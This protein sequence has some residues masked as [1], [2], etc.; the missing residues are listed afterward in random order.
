[1]RIAY[2]INGL[3]IPGGLERIVCDKANAIC[4]IPGYEVHIVVK[5]T[6]TKASAAFP[7]DPK[8]HIGQAGLPFDPGP[9]RS[10]LHPA[11][12][13]VK[14]LKWRKKFRQSVAA[15]LTEHKIDIA[16]AAT[17]DAALPYFTNV[18]PIIY[19]SHIH[20]EYTA[21]DAPVAS[22][23]KY[24]TKRNVRRAAA[25]VSLTDTDARLWPEA[26]RMEVIPNFTNIRPAAPYNPDA[27][28]VM[29]A[30]RF[31][32][33]KGFDILVKAWQI[34][35]RR[36]PE[37]TLDIYGDY[38]DTDPVYADILSQI[39]EAGLSHRIELKGAEADMATAYA[40]HSVFVLSS[41]YEGFGLVLLEAMTCGVPCVSF[42]CPSG[43]ADI[44]ADGVD[45]L[46]VPFNGLPDKQRVELLA[47][48][49]CRMIADR[50]M[51]VRLSAHAKEKAGTFVR[52]EIIARW[53][54][55]FED[56]IKNRE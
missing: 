46:L 27:T 42:D 10:P 8:I 56:I 21:I 55:L 20:R 3:H 51:R 43:P 9:G 54:A 23:R 26:Q 34:V 19:E 17:H 18:C 1:M 29:G 14:W 11:A 13:F 38:S 6:R 50:D 49:L 12:T 47:D 2:F 22:L 41:R 31:H 15:Y 7:I 37:W 44:I 40:D 35:A 25:I 24:L 28:R 45:G 5:N 39:N 48:A 52:D 30:G 16:I 4:N 36:F 32:P 33:Q 53:T